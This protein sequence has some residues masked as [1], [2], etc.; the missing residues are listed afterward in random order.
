M[1][2]LAFA[3]TFLGIGYGPAPRVCEPI[4]QYYGGKEDPEYLQIDEG[5]PLVQFV[6]SEPSW[7]YGDRTT[8][9]WS[10]V[11]SRPVVKRLQPVGGLRV[12]E[13]VY[14]Q[15]SHVVVWDQG[16][17]TFCPAVLLSADESIVTR[18]HDAEVFSW[19]GADV[20][21]LRVEIAGAG[22]FQ[23]SLFFTPVDGRLK[24]VRQN[25]G[26]QARLEAF[27]K[28]Q[29]VQPYHRGAGVCS[30]MLAEEIMVEGSHLPDGDGGTAPGIGGVGV[31]YRLEGESMVIDEL[32]LGGIK[33]CEPFA[34][35]RRR[36]TNSSRSG[37]ATRGGRVPR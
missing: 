6:R 11:A 14:S 4:W 22:H 35:P 13:V 29:D 30:G 12:Y 26:N 37:A 32:H 28:K 24:H 17:W 5:W 3:A 7:Y 8:L 20:V 16:G 31:T 10:P 15:L 21:H 34:E 27:F 2:G 23:E 25:P 18:I 19:R 36:P 9:K 33:G 1:L